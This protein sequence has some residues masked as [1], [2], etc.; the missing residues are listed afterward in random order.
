MEAHVPDR[1]R[2]ASVLVP[3]ARAFLYAA[4]AT[5]MATP[6]RTAFSLLV[7]EEPLTGVLVAIDPAGANRRTRVLL[8]HGLVPGVPPGVAIRPE[9]KVGASR[10]DFLLTRAGER[11]LL[12]VK[13]V[14][15]TRA[16]VARFPDAPTLRGVRHLEELAAF[17]RAGEGTAMVLFVVQRGD[18]T[19]VGPD[20]EIDPLFAKTLRRL[21]GTLRLAAVGF[22]VHPEG[23]RFQGEL[24][25]VLG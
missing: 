8:E 13:S 21:S 20:D 14:G 15:V 1:G 12:E 4:P 7:C 9:V 10:L 22:D 23:S 6:R 25:V 24:P 17:A 2:L 19:A 11:L 16:G 5:P 18:A 3:G